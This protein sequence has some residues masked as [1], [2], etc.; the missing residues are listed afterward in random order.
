MLYACT[1][2]CGQ[3]VTWMGRTVWLRSALPSRGAPAANA[4][5]FR[6]GPEAA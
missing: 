5:A 1:S 6:S 4:A 3:R 2:I